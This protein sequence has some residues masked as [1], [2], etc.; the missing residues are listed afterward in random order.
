MN[1]Y[2][3][4]LPTAY[5]LLPTAYCL[6]FAAGCSMSSPP[7]FK[8]NTEGRDPN[9]IGLAQKDA[10]MGTLERLFGTPDEPLVPDGVDLDRQLLEAAAGPIRGDQQGNQ[11][12][13]YRQHC[14]L[15][16]GPSG[17][18]AGPAAAVLNPYPRDFRNGLFKFTSTAGGAKPVREDLHRAL[19]IGNA[20][21][22]MPSFVLLPQRELDALVEYVEYLSIRGETEL[23]LLELV[24]DEDEYLP[25]DLKQV[26]QEGVLPAAESWAAARRVVVDRQ[27]A[28][29]HAPFSP[30]ESPPTRQLAGS[31][32]QGRRLYASEKAKCVECHGPAGDGRGE[33]RE[34]YDDW[35][36]PKKGAT[37]EQTRELAR[38]SQLPIQRIWPRDFT[39]GSFRGG[40]RPIDQYWRVHVGIKGT[41]MP[42]A[43]PAP[44]T[45]GVLAPE[46]IWHLVNYVRSLAGVM[47][48]DLQ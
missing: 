31:V 27:E 10:I 42:A 44:G 14:V 36:K 32:A 11:W 2:L 16:H 4:L 6:L 5:C 37:P 17:D 46:E 18:G 7:Q 19:S 24:V 48:S 35:N 26:V 22:A 45:A 38:L 20:E 13:L 25:L 1:C 34:L 12:G 40:R 9:Q 33:Q 21:T 39:R 23:Y 15:C 43:G 28:L 47:G 30:T 8:L 3:R 41:P 29:R